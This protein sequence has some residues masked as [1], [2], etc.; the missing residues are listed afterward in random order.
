[1]PISKK[2]KVSGLVLALGFATIGIALFIQ[3]QRA[4]NRPASLVNSNAPNSG[5]PERPHRR[6]K[7][8]LIWET[9]SKIEP[10]SKKIPD[11]VKALL[12]TQVRIA[13]FVIANDATSATEFS[14]FLI[15]PVSGGCVHVPPPP[16]NYVLHV[17]TENGKPVALPYGPVVVE[18]ILSLPKS[19]EDQKY[20]AFELTAKTVEDYRNSKDRE[21][22]Q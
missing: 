18:G 12:N 10:E 21:E 17:K 19:K 5:E 2:L 1:M 13:G 11:E 4:A 7:S 20:Y 22:A 16:P 8:V 9:L 14:E 3:K 15:T 6:P